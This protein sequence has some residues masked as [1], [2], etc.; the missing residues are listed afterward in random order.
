M[1]RVPPPFH[2]DRT[3]R[4]PV[5]PEVFWSTIART[6]DYASW[7]K[8]LRDFDAPA[9]AE[10]Q[11]WQATIQS[12]L[13]Y[14]LRFHLDL[15]EVEAPTLLVVNVSGDIA[16]PAR[17]EIAAE[18]DGGC[19]VPVSW[20]ADARSGPLPMG[21]LVARPLLQCSHEAVVATSLAHFGRRLLQLP[22]FAPRRP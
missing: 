6:E 22:S 16:G 1:T 7:W 20:K 12:P 5:S 19:A 2:F 10:G 21:A 9:L 15:R 17:L 18:D 11:R 13:P 14:A 4:F 3:W 8:W